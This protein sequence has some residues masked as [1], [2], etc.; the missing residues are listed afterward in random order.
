MDKKLTVSQLNHYIKGVFEDELILHGVSVEGE[1]FE[2]KTTDGNS[3]ITLTE[4][5]CILNCVYF[6]ST[7]PYEVGAKV[8]A[9]GSVEFYPKRG[10]L[11]FVIKNIRLC[12]EGEMA[13]RRKML[14]NKLLAE[15]V[16][17]N[18]RPLKN[19]VRSVALITSAEG[20]VLH[21]FVSVLGRL[22]PYIDI[23]IFSVKVQG[24]GASE[25][26][27]HTMSDITSKNIKNF[28]TIVI[29]RGGGSALDLDE[30]NTEM[31]AR[32][33]HSSPIT[34][35]S[36]V[37]HETDYTLCD[38]AADIRAGTPSIAAEIIANN[39]RKFFEVLFGTAGNISARISVI[40]NSKNRAVAKLA[41]RLS[42]DAFDTISNAYRR[43]A[44]LN[45]LLQVSTE[46]TA[47]MRQKKMSDMTKKMHQSL[48][49]HLNSK[50]S[51][52]KILCAE[53]DKLSPLKILSKGYARVIKDQKIIKSIKNISTGDSVEI[54]M[55][56]G[57]AQAGI[58]SIRKK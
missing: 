27:I 30:F 58:I 2:F 20:A 55:A 21:D 44:K 34:V 47:S 1:I 42:A 14:K 46:K 35:I 9:I 6:S 26:I 52:F 36:A 19:V 10:R 3:F 28:D 50:E 12:G 17:A 5:D 25:E 32:A 16:F 38:F 15:G 45:Y 57:S 49:N 7:L 33:V 4:G 39:N 31:L 53:A 41:E 13:A 11:S 56:D 43:I 48:L 8:C 23:T 22:A 40:F 51:A 54:V 29:A 18:D 24:M 37:G